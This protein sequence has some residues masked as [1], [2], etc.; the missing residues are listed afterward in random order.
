MTGEMAAAR[1]GQGGSTG[2]P[3]RTIGGWID[4][5]VPMKSEALSLAAG[6]RAATACALPVLV[7]EASGHHE[8]SWI[9]IVAF[10]GCLADSGGAWRTRLTAM[11]SFT[12][13]ATI[14]C[15]LAM[16]AARSI[17]LA[18]PFA[19]V[20]SFGSS[21][22]RIYGNNA[23]VVG[24]LLVA[25]IIVCLGTPPASLT[26]AIERMGMTLLGGAWATLLV[27]VIWRL[28]PYGPARRCIAACWDAVA[29]YADA[30]GHLHRGQAADPA[31]VEADWAQVI[32][33]RRAA[34]REAIELGRD[35]LAGERRRRAGESRRG[36]LLLVLLAD[37]DQVF[38]ALTALSEM[39]ETKQGA[40]GSSTQRALRLMLH[41]I[42]RSAAALPAS[43]AE[44]RAPA[45][46]G[47]AR[48]L[49][50][51]K[52][53]LARMPGGTD[54]SFE[55]AASLLDRIVQY[56]DVAI[57]TAGGVLPPSALPRAEP[58]PA[59]A[60]RPGIWAP[61]RA[62]L[63]PR[64]LIARHALR[65]AIAAAMS[66]WLADYFG[67]ERGYWIG[68][69]A[70]V[71][72]QPFLAT[73]W[74]RAVERVV[75]SVLGGLIAAAIGL[76][77]PQPMA[78]VAVLF[79]LSVATMAV[80][81]V[82]YALFVLLLTPQFVLIAELFQTGLAPDAH[83]AGLRALDSVLGGM[84]GLA[85]G[86][87]LWPSWETTQ[88][89]K[90]L[91]Q[92]LRAN[93]DYLAAVLAGAPMAEVQ[94]ARRAAGLASNNAEASFQR[95]LSEPRRRPPAAAEP[96][97]T[98]LGCLRR[99][100]GAAATLSL[101]PPKTRAAAALVLAGVRDGTSASIEAIAKAIEQ[102]ATVPSPQPMPSLPTEG[103]I[104]DEIERIQR[105][106]DVIHGAAERLVGAKADPLAD[107]KG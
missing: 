58:V 4:R 90:Q 76:V 48:S 62:N 23:T 42:A 60:P 46:S 75:G 35:V 1:T 52:A 31:K 51:V 57:D 98:M 92:A 63:A 14:G 72:L 33:S 100:A 101:V 89:P 19:L 45:P 70:V 6:L 77:L 85:A 53:H 36:A 29:A 41:R 11:A 61:L 2:R 86:F 105:Q 67:L 82:N 102:G 30:L 93:R 88:L 47:L 74:Q 25:E 49:A 81:G 78:V 26:D 56:F 80:R 106:L 79:P 91:V 94:A 39:L 8:L 16:L 3:W 55:H 27:V 59:A 83:L 5:A 13:L 107:E 43:L 34:A 66:V 44:G 54:S 40:G 95:L 64:S 96:A 15:L 21:L 71:I 97:M 18:V 17:W 24:S 99:L 10:W 104:K 68:I 32:R 87:L 50:R 12:G 38:E 69:T 84:L 73:T 37:A 9:A 65:L 103:V 28:S 22:A 20:W 7:A